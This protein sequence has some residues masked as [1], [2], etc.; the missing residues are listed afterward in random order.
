VR[1]FEKSNAR[2]DLE[3]ALNYKQIKSCNIMWL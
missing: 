2:N 3:A 1:N